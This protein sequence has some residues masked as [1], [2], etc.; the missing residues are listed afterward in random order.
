MASDLLTSIL[1]G[2][3][4]SPN[5]F[6]GR[7]LSG[8]DLNMEKAANRDA[9]R[10]LGRALG[11]GVAFGFQVVE[12]ADLSTIDRPVVTIMPGLAVNRRGQTL[13]L[14]TK[15]DVALAPSVETEEPAARAFYDCIPPSPDAYI[16]GGGVY[17][18]VV[19]P[20][21][22]KEGRAPMSS[23]GDSSASCNAKN[24][25]ECLRFRLIKLDVS[26][27]DL[28]DVA[29]L[30]NRI[31]YKCFGLTD[32]GYTGNV[33]NPF[34]EHEP[35]YGMLDGMRLTSLT[36]CDVPLALIYWNTKD[37]IGFIDAW[38]VRRRITSPGWEEEW[39][40]HLSTRRRKE[41][42]AMFSQF[43]EQIEA[44]R[45][46]DQPIARIEAKSR[47]DYLPPV[48]I[49]PFSTPRT[50]GTFD[51]N[52]F[53]GLAVR[54]PVFINGAKL[55]A[56]ICNS[57]SYP[58]IDLNS[59]E[60]IWLYRVRENGEAINKGKLAL[61]NSYIVFSTGQIPYQGEAQFDLS[62]WDYGNYAD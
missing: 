15:T 45:G 47:F 29:H 34:G 18:I 58:P 61:S 26:E 25:V 53:N 21:V 59:E 55:Q 44:I 52:F 28:A 24:I 17:L 35:G 22:E 30:R 11:D 37:G 62:Y 4:R 48:G 31:A 16:A 9:R 5:F 50:S 7:L 13:M 41:G 14:K 56:L 6:N 51:M 2:G 49:I 40:P 12:N 23:L 20:A 57:F 60:M 32:A 38:A 8:E 46:K 19:R 36:D 3:I 27:E 33:S 1:E 10:H 43:Q 54:D 39:L 42:E